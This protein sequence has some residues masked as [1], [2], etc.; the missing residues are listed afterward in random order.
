MPLDLLLKD[1]NQKTI[2]LIMSSFL[3]AILGYYFG[4]LYWQTKTNNENSNSQLIQQVFATQNNSRDKPQQIAPLHLFGKADKVIRQPVK[5]ATV[6]PISR[7]NLTLKGVFAS[8]PIESSLAIISSGKRDEL[9]YAI[10]E[11]LPGGA[12]LKEVYS[13]R[14]IIERNGS[15]ETLPLLL[16]EAKIIT[17]VETPLQNEQVFRSTPKELRVQLLKDP[18]QIPKIMA[19]IAQYKNGKVIGFKLQMKKY[20]GILQQYGLRKTDIVT[21]INGIDITNSKNAFKLLQQLTNAPSL[22]L[23]ILRNGQKQSL[24]ISLL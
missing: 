17:T 21:A 1:K 24:S 10:G 11:T 14:V 12:T 3:M 4:M 8:E 16:E 5:K 19:T 20:K 22:N 13:D 6:A 9:L 7:L 23:D 2:A 18:S 15:L